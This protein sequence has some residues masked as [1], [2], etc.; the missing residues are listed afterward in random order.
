MAKIPTILE[1][2]RA[3]GKL[4]TSGAIFDEN[5]SM[6]QSELNDVQDTLSSDNP[7]KPLSAKQGKVLKELLD[8][9][10]IE[11]GAVPIDTNP[12]EGNI[13]HVVS[14]DGLAKEFNKCSTEIIQGGVYDVSAHNNSKVFE[15]L[16]SLLNNSNLDTLI[17]ISVRHGGMSIRFIQSSDNKYVQFM[18]TNQNWSIDVNDWTSGE[19]EFATGEKVSKIGI[20]DNPTFGSNNLVKSG[21]VYTSLKEL[22][23]EINTKFTMLENAGYQ[24]AGVATK[25]TNPNTP[26][27]KVF[28][29]A[30]GKGVYT[31]FDGINVTEDEVVILYFDTAWHKEITGIAS[32]T[33]ITELNEKV[34]ALALGEFYGYFPNSSSLPI[35]VTTRGYAYVGLDNPYKI[36]NFNGVSW[37]DSGTSIDMNDADEE[38]ITR[39]VD[40]KLQFKDRAYGDGMGY[41]ILRKDKTL[42]EQVTKENTIYEIRYDFDLNNTEIEMPKG[43]MFK[44]NGGSISVGE[45]KIT[46]KYVFAKHI[47]ML[48]N[49]NIPNVQTNNFKILRFFMNLGF[50]VII[51]DCYYI[52]TTGE[53]LNNLNIIGINKEISK[54]I[55][56]NFGSDG[57]FVINSNI[58][59]I[60]IQNI[61]FDTTLEKG[62]LHF[63]RLISVLTKDKDILI[64]N[65][66]I[67][68]CNIY[69]IRIFYFEGVDKDMSWGKWG[70]KRFVI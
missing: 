53:T 69:G 32:Q 14:S 55:C 41:V 68:N 49:L 9:K 22:E 19:S 4:V 27:A 42:A 48:P 16:Y 60:T 7:N 47:G 65:I 59:S 40:G 23:S 46:D 51:D 37:S 63:N 8:T 30:D 31:N 13:T 64:K 21:G 61:T 26:D 56:T 57:V 54:I 39:N 3:D 58:E 29:I 5:K 62:Y 36:W 33:S 43:S 38:D 44:F 50:V 34:D 35:D 67:N 6:F 1:P 66:H 28:Y 12:I 2:G 20:D 24:F 10:V 25:D 17:P 11:A 18:L 15:S 45:V 52:S 70:I